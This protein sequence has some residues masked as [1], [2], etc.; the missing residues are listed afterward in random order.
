MGLAVARQA[1]RGRRLARRRGPRD[2]IAHRRHSSAIEWLG[3][4]VGRLRRVRGLGRLGWVRRFRGLW[5]VRRWRWRRL[6]EAEPLA[7]QK[8]LAFA[9]AQSHGILQPVAVAFAQPVPELQ[10]RG[11][12]AGQLRLAQRRSVY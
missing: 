8:Q 5:W 10:R 7:Q 12:V 11:P 3:W 6:A 1:R 2:R 4:F 9:V